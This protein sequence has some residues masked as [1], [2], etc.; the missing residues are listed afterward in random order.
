[1][2]D[3]DKDLMPGT[4]A[5][6]SAIFS[7]LECYKFLFH[8]AKQ[9]HEVSESRPQDGYQHLWWAKTMFHHPLTQE[10]S[11]YL[12]Q[13]HKQRIDETRKPWRQTS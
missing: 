12:Y 3:Q 4:C 9:P 13:T 1:V 7:M 11:C 8:L 10:A 5:E 2:G 6:N